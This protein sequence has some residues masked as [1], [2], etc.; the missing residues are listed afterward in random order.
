M[1]YDRDPDGMEIEDVLIP[2][3]NRPSSLKLTVENLIPVYEF[4]AGVESNSIQRVATPPQRAS[5][6]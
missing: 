5:M 6:R 3:E 4:I 2:V 1:F